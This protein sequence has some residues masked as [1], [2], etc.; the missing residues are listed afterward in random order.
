MIVYNFIMKHGFVVSNWQIL[1]IH[2]VFPLVFDD[3]FH[4]KTW[5]LIKCHN[6]HDKLVVSYSRTDNDTKYILMVED[7]K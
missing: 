5:D 4:G 7:V 1:A 6:L 3:V 2:S